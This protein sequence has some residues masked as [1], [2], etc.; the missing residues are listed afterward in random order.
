[1]T[2]TEVSTEDHNPIG[3]LAESIQDVLGMN[4]P[5]THHPYNPHI[6][7]ILH[8][9]NTREISSGVGAPVAAEG[10]DFWFKTHLFYS[11]LR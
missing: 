1:M 2:F 9:G 11:L 7:R 8:S 4:H 6:V 3:T 5:R 10:N